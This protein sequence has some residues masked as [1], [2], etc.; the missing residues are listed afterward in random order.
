M[1]LFVSSSITD[2]IFFNI[3]ILSNFGGIRFKNFKG[4]HKV[5]KKTCIFLIKEITKEHF[6]FI[7]AGN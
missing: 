1:I 5:I 6:Y 2:S 3:S 7:L 4:I